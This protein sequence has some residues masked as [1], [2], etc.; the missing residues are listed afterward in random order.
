MKHKL[1]DRALVFFNVGIIQFVIDTILLQI[2]FY[3]G[4]ELT[5]ANV[6]SR[7]I[8]AC[9]GCFLNYQYTFRSRQNIKYI[10]F[11]QVFIR[12]VCFWI[13]MTILS[14]FLLRMI[15]NLITNYFLFLPLPGM[16]AKIITEV[17]LFF[18]S[19]FI[20]KFWVFNHGK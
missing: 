8:A 4:I 19:F 13:M 11:I 5:V 7:G 9:L 20:S 3:L 14:N 1:F 18:I 17:I 10:Y 15:F 6:I 16:I 12:F 2:L